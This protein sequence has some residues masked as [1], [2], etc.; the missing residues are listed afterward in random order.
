MLNPRSSACGGTGSRAIRPLR[1]RG[2]WDGC[3]SGLPGDGAGPL[4]LCVNS[5][6]AS[7]HPT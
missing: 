1:K 3:D 2:C 4:S 7:T 6:T 5:P